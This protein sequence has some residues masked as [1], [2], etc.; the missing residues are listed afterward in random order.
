MQHFSP[1]TRWLLLALLLPLAAQ[2]QTGGV[3]IGTITPDASA[4]LEIK[5]TSQGL[6]LPRLS[7][8]QRDALTA[9]PTAPPVPGLVIYQTDNTPAFTPTT[10]WPGSRQ[11][12]QPHRHSNPGPARQRLDRHRGRP[13]HGGRRGH[14]G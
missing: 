14:P 12:G 13:G 3:G 8:V 10:G 11:P 2:A 5:S 7:L 4:A 1:L 9:S 6:L